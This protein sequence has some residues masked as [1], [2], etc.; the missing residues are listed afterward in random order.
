[1]FVIRDGKAA[2][3]PIKTGHRSTELVEVLEGLNAGEEVILYPS[4]QVQ[5]GVKVQE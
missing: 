3:Q 5:D 2:H 1:M 4:D